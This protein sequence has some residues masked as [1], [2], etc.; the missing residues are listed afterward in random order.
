RAAGWRAGLYT[1]PHLVDVRER[2]IV[3]DRPIPAEAFAEWTA[4][5]LP[6]VEETGAS[7]F[8]ATTAIAFAD[9]AARQVEIAVVEV[10]LGGRLDA[11]NVLTPV[12]SAITH[13]ARDHTEYLGES[14]EAIAREKAGI[15]K[16]GT[17]LI[18]GESDPEIVSVIRDAASASG[19]PIVVVSSDRP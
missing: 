10:G 14:L 18:V 17:P 4:R 6:T 2:F 11:T 13:I 3:N 9:L 19:A 16:P 8:E 12:V 7:F 15:A 5:I 1:S